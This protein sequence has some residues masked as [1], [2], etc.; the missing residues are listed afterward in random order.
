MDRITFELFGLILAYMLIWG[1]LTFAGS[2]IYKLRG[3][4]GCQI[5]GKWT[6]LLGIT[7]LVLM[8]LLTP[9]RE[10]ILLVMGFPPQ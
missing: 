9:T 6:L 4:Q 3:G 8:F 1:G 5:P 7:A 2:I 10:A